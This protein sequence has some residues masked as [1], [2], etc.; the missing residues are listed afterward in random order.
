MTASKIRFGAVGGGVLL[1]VLYFAGRL[2]GETPLSGKPACA[3]SPDVGTQTNCFELYNACRPMNLVVESLDEDAAEIGL[4]EERIRTA[5]ESR[6]R[7][8]RLHSDDPRWTYLYV[9]VNVGR[10]AFSSSA[11]YKKWLRDVEF[12]LS[13]VAGTWDTGVTG[14]H[15]GDAGYILQSVSEN[16]DRF[17]VEYLRVN[18]G[19]CG[20]P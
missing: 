9:N 15:G 17:I 5:V 19:A 10:R 6:L 7:S 1:V 12:D 3:D 8:A 16:V 18:E 20:G 2:A 14:T 4:T 11:R 13:G